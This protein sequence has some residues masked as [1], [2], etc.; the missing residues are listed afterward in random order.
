MPGFRSL[1]RLLRATTEMAT[2]F[3]A[4]AFS[5]A[6]M[7]SACKLRLSRPSARRSPCAGAD[8]PALLDRHADLELHFLDDAL[9]EARRHRTSRSSRSGPVHRAPSLDRRPRPGGRRLHR[10]GPER[11]R[12]ISTTATA[13]T[14]A[15]GFEYKHART[16]LLASRGYRGSTPVE[17]ISMSISPMARPLEC[18]QCKNGQRNRTDS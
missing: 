5:S 8:R 7:L 6:A 17:Q 13:D 2:S 12:S 3:C 9:A 10:S 4:S 15:I 14:T 16:S 1:S 11:P 18:V